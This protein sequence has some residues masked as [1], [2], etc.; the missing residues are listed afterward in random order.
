MGTFKKA[1]K[2][3][4]Y[5]AILYLKKIQSTWSVRLHKHHKYI[6]VYIHTKSH[7]HYD[8]YY[9]R[10]YETYYIKLYIIYIRRYKKI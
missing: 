9:V 1:V 8:M 10:S 5:A 3:T 7:G 6:L 4:K 2:N